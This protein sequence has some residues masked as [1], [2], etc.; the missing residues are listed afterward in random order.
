MICIN[1]TEVPL[2]LIVKIYFKMLNNIIQYRHMEKMIIWN[3]KYYDFSQFYN[4]IKPI[5][6]NLN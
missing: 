6:S 4:Y 1:D 5:L 3:Y 2:F